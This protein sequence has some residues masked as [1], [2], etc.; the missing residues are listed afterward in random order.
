M[1]EHIF[2]QLSER[3]C[4]I[5]KK[6]DLTGL[7]VRGDNYN[8]EIYIKN[9]HALQLEIDWHENNLFMYVVYLKN[10]EL[11]DKNVI[12][13]Y[14]DGQWCRKYLEEIYKTK[15]PQ[16][17]DRSKRYSEQYLFECLGFYEKLIEKNSSVLQEFFKSILKG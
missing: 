3:F 13:N 14:E 17:K 12:Y 2:N 9:N 8:S 6:L 16:Q 7:I 5:G 15:R 10:N 4:E 11:P 1:K